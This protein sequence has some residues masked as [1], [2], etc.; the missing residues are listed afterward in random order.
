MIKTFSETLAE[1]MGHGSGSA[2]K[3]TKMFVEQWKALGSLDAENPL[4]QLSETATQILNTRDQSDRR[5]LIDGAL[6]LEGVDPNVSATQLKNLCNGHLSWDSF[7]EP[8]GI[9]SF[10]MEV[11]GIAG[12]RSASVTEHVIRLRAYYNVQSSKD[13]V[14]SILKKDVISPRS[15]EE[16]IAILT[17]QSKIIKIFTHENFILVINLEDFWNL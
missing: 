13:E 5:M 3:A 15:V 12:N 2:P 9:T 14:D 4:E 6:S 7:E 11:S 1:N 16:L 8:N 17:Q 10:M